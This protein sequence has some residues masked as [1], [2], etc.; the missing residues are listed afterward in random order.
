MSNI[1]QK[2][3]ILRK[4]I[5]TTGVTPSIPIN[6]DHTTGWLPTD[7]YEGET[8]MN[9]VDNTVYVRTLSQTVRELLLFDENRMVSNVYLPSTILDGAIITTYE[10]NT[11]ENSLSNIQTQLDNKLDAPHTHDNYVKNN[12]YLETNSFSGDYLT[13]DYNN[14]NND[15]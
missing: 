5:D 15:Y 8:I 6:N 3:R 2:S 13:F 11:L 9:A 10:L 1:E 12:T 4:R 7:I 14:T